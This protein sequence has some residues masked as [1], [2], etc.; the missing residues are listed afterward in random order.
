[1]A[2][3][4]ILI[5]GGTG[6]LGYH[7]AKKC[8]KKNW[9]VTIFS[10]NKPKKKRYL[11]KKVSYIKGDISKIRDLKKM[12]KN[13][14]YVV[15]FGGYVN[16]RNKKV[17]Y[18][19]HFTG[20]KNLVRIFSK[21]KI[22]LFLQISS[23]AEYGYMKSPH[24]ENMI[25]RP[26]TGYAKAKNLATK[27]LITENIKNNFPCVILRLYQV[28]GEKQDS[29][30]IIPFIIES[31][32]DKKTFPCSDGKQYKDFIEVDEVMKAIFKIFKLNINGEIINI[33]S[34]K[35][36]Q[37]KKIIKFICKKIKT[38]TPQFGKIKIRKE[39]INKYYPSIKKAKSL[40]NWS[41]ELNFERKIV[42]LINFQK[43][44]RN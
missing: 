4:K 8:L 19:S 33:G 12:Q 20:C 43:K 15:N 37:I 34:G 41:P 1:M 44:E 28:Y 27:F 11:G 32:L 24:K 26:Q 40:I 10:L 21:N 42:S 3:N 38:G 39:E 7:L 36:L 35:A 14:D 22:K 16:H 13:F 23:G 31:C 29:N 18:N 30:R 2:K 25:C 17:V 5:I 6:F 9:K